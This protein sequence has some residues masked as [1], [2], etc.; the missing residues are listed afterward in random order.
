MISYNKCLSLRFRAEMNLPPKQTPYGVPKPGL[1]ATDCQ[2]VRIVYCTFW[3]RLCQT[4]S[5][6]GSEL[7]LGGSAMTGRAE[8]ASVWCH[9]PGLEKLGAGPRPQTFDL[10]R[11]T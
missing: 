8:S 4:L 6:A 10:L 11:G 2:S 7:V 1:T 3:A 5:R 9:Q